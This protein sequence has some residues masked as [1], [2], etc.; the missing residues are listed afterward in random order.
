[1]TLDYE[2]MWFDAE[3]NR[4][5]EVAVPRTLFNEPDPWRLLKDELPIYEIGRTYD[6]PSR[7]AVI[8]QGPLKKCFTDCEDWP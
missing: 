6:D 2:L 5:A 4:W 1:M 7:F 3:G 8:L